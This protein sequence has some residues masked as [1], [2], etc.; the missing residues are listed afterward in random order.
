MLCVLVYGGNGLPTVNPHHNDHKSFYQARQT[1]TVVKQLLCRLRTQYV[2][3]VADILTL[4]AVPV[5]LAE[6]SNAVVQTEIRM[7]ATTKALLN[8][9]VLC[10]MSLVCF[11][12]WFCSW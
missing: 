9:R 7:F 1:F 5:K 3:V 2:A 12:I 10:K 11:A 8:R 6:P 4:K